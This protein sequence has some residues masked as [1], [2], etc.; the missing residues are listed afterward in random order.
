VPEK[1]MMIGL[2]EI[3]L[4]DEGRRQVELQV[5]VRRPYLLDTL[6]YFQYNIFFILFDQSYHYC[7][8][9]VEDSH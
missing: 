8:G 1:E 5:F 9:K 4:A 7:M 6:L 3:H 2:G